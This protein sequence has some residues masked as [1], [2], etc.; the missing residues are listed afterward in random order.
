[1]CV[2]IYFKK[3]STSARWHAQVARKAEPWAQ[4]VFRKHSLDM[5]GRTH[6]SWKHFQ[7]VGTHDKERFNPPESVGENT[8]FFL[9]VQLCVY[10]ACKEGQQSSFSA[11]D[12][13]VASALMVGTAGRH[14][15]VQSFQ[16]TLKRT[17]FL[18][19]RERGEREPEPVLGGLEGK[20]NSLDFYLQELWAREGH[21]Q[22]CVFWFVCYGKERPGV[23]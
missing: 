20:R 9:T 16:A 17:A 1:M 13:G 7:S 4:P 23:G 15:G 12:S 2:V 22:I 6:V 5:Y 8:T 18:D 14:D 11:G 3:V 19:S 10:K 21:D